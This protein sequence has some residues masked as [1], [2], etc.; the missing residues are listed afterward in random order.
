VISICIFFISHYDKKDIHL[1]TNNYVGNRFIDGFFFY[2]TWLGDGAMAVVLLLT[3]I[4]YNFR[5]GIYATVSFLTASLA[6]IGLKH[7]FFDDENRPFFIF[8]NFTNIKLR[9]IEGVD[10]YIHN[11]FPS[12]HATQA[13]AIFMCLAF[14]SGKQLVK[15]T[16]L[17]LA[18]LTAYSRIHLSQHWLVDITAG[19][20]VGTFFAILY[21]FVFINNGKFS[22]LNKP[23][24]V[25]IRYWRLK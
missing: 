18:I 14:V 17:L 12:G 11:S 22:R 19:S 5:L 10:V 1:Y 24:F 3:I 15:L 4:A 2:I 9:L 25:F 20:V 6:S 7:F 21:Y 23:I 13:F 16:F 8:D